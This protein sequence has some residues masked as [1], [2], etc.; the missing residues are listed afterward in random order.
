VQSLQNRTREL[1]NQALKL[2]FD[3]KIDSGIE[4]LKTELDSASADLPNLDK[5]RL[6]A[7][8]GQLLSHRAFLVSTGC[9]EAI[10]ALNSAIELAENL[11]APLTL[12]L[13]YCYRGFA[14]YTNTFHNNIGTY[15]DAMPDVAHAIGISEEIDDFKGLAH[16]LVY[17][18]ILYER[19][20]QLDK[21]KETYQR[22]L[23]VSEGH[24][25]DL[26]SS[27]ALRHLAFLRHNDGDLDGALEYFERSLEL[28]EKVGFRTGLALSHLAVGN[29]LLD[30][31]RY[32]EANEQ[33]A[34]SAQFAEELGLER[35]TTLCHYLIGEVH[36]RQGHVNRAL[37]Q[38]ELSK[39][40]SE[41]IGYAV[42]VQRAA[43][44]IAETQIQ[45]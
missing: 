28:R 27:Y 13:A 40:L 5:A 29:V 10:E 16:A 43:D 15:Q 11:D 31:D 35:V 2:Y 38:F 18:G 41:K 34:K 9:D 44:R 7:V 36:A 21:A 26:E 1:E 45:S 14:M 24:I 12:S 33:L 42:G 19:T 3:G 8:L 17:E 32:D 22:A 4:L 6:L 39:D 23:D 25:H 37:L 30:M 20:E